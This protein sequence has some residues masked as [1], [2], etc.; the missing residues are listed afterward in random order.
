MIDFNRIQGT[1]E[2]FKPMLENEDF[3]R[4]GNMLVKAGSNGAKKIMGHFETVR[5]NRQSMLTSQA[6]GQIETH[7]AGNMTGAVQQLTSGGASAALGG[8]TSLGWANLAVSGISIGVTVAS[9]IYLSKKIEKI[10][11]EIQQINGK[12]DGIIDEMHQIKLMVVQLNDNEI[13]KLYTEANRQIRRMNDYADELNNMEYN[14]ATAREVRNFLTDSSAFLEDI[15]GRYNDT[16]CDISLGL[17]IIMAH[18]YTYVSL[19][20]TYISVVYL[21]E[22]KIDDHDSHETILRN[23]C[24]KSM[25]DSIQD[26]YLLS[27]DSFISPQDLGLITSVYKGIMVE[28]I[29]EIKSQRK[30]L[31]L[32]DYNQY[33]RLTEQL[34]EGSSS[35][36]LAYIQYT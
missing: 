5:A 4:Y 13:R 20:K 11:Q 27:A 29:S 15:L 36:E 6:A 8:L 19:L 3:K 17:D 23:M 34:Q 35:G 32:V 10:N 14:H 12:L 1:Y 21:H 22:K 28:Q 31:E 9:T 2:K 33:K 24:S 25:I 7:L 18:F 30:I 26:A 16:N